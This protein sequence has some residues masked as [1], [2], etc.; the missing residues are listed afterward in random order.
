MFRMSPRTF[1]SDAASGRFL[2]ARGRGSIDSDRLGVQPQTHAVPCRARSSTVRQD[3]A[4]R[5]SA[6]GMPRTVSQCFVTSGTALA[7]KSTLPMQ[8]HSVANLFIKK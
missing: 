8:Q 5:E 2:R 6:A 1:L 4:T 3:V 7:F